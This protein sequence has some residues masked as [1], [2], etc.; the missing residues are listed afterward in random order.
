[1]RNFPSLQNLTL[2]EIALSL[3]EQEIAEEIWL[4]VQS[5]CGALRELAGKFSVLGE[6]LPLVG[7]F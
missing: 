6:I 5:F 2:V 4:S 7:S 1:M 3:T